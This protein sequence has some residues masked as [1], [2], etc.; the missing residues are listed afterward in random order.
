MQS[1]IVPTFTDL[2]FYSNPSDPNIQTRYNHI[3]ELFNEIYHGKPLFISR[4]P[5]RVNLIGDHI[6]YCYFPVLP[7]ALDS[8]VLIAVSL[9]SSNE[10]N[11]YNTNPLFKQENFKLNSNSTS[12][13]ITEIDQS[14]FTWINYFK[15]GLIVAHK[16]ILENY[17]NLIKQFNGGQI[18]GLNLLFDG[19]VPTGGG[20]SSSAAI[21]VAS[22]LAV[23]KANGIANISKKDLTKITI[24]S[25]HYLGVNTGGMDQCASINGDKKKA[26]LVQFKPFLKSLQFELPILKP[27]DMVFLITNSLI[28]ANK[29]ETSSINYN[30]RVVEA[31]ISAE[32]LAYKFNLNLIKDSNLST[33]S[34]GTL[35][36]FMD[37]YFEKILNE[38][39]W[40]GNNIYIGSKR[41]TKLMELIETIFTKEEKQFG[42]T[43]KHAAESLGLNIKEFKSRFLNKFPI[44][45]ENL[46]LYQRTKHILGEALRVLEV[47][48]LF[49]NEKADINSDV[50]SSNKFLNKFGELLNISQISNNLLIENSKPECEFLCKIAKE[51]GSYGSR[52]TGAG[53][54]GSIVH[55]TTIDKLPNLINAIKN[56]YFLVKWPNITNDELK[57]VILIS[58]PSTGSCIVEL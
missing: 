52:I 19:N 29:F 1:D 26:L 8:D 7:M 16:F 57:Q 30:L 51:N 40:D 36:G 23:L 13:S 53:F 35:R 10:I 17:P 55:L 28:H 54:G 43:T 9:N 31:A 5:G 38:S 27:N 33:G 3:F 41:L 47:L 49:E 32:F 45:Y 20:L 50:D 48:K 4:S 37:S 34:A 6:D 15:C 44:K 46:K 42:F 12:T 56:Q 58:Q 22:T 25:E 18:T 2:S 21:C 11:L 24:V 14:N 39:K